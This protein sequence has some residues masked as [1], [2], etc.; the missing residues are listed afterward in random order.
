MTGHD[1]VGV[2][3]PP[4]VPRRVSRLSRRRTW[5]S[6]VVIGTVAVSAASM[7]ILG[8]W[9]YGWP[10]SFAD[11]I[12]YAPYNRHLIHDAGRSRSGSASAS[13]PR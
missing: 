10:R 6:I 1:A 5:V 7:F 4:H 11:F 3:A 8:L 13:P 9:A 2:A 12:D